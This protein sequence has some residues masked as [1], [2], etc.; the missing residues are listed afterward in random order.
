MR[1]LSL[2][3]YGGIKQ[4]YCIGKRLPLACTDYIPAAAG[5]RVCPGVGVGPRLRVRPV[6]IPVVVPVVVL[7]RHE[8][9]VVQVPPSVVTEVGRP[10]ASRRRDREPGRASRRDGRAGD[11]HGAGQVR[12]ISEGN[13]LASVERRNAYSCQLISPGG[14][15]M[16]RTIC[17]QPRISSPDGQLP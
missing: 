7:D 17:S 2:R 11:D 3:R 1:A 5:A 6:V 8:L 9:V 14:F 10:V 12:P 4:T 13:G 15:S 16:P